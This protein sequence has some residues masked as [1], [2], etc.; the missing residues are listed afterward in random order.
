ML[1][2]HL[3]IAFRNLAKQEGHGKTELMAGMMP[4]LPGAIRDELTG[5]ETVAAFHHYLAKV[6]VPNSGGA[7]PNVP[8]AIPNVPGAIP[9][10]TAAPRRFDAA[11]R[12]EEPSPIYSLDHH[13]F[14]TIKAAI[15]NPIKSLRTD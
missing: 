2:N 9:N 7:N 14:Q 5:F 11:H 13:Q 4:P 10:S 3:R 12:D 15:V 6:T 1:Q 8:G